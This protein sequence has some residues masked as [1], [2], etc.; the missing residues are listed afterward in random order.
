M[1]G[2]QLV[3]KVGRTTS[4]TT[5]RVIGKLQGPIIIPYASSIHNFSGPVYLDS[6]FTIAGQIGPFSDSGDSGSLVVTTPDANGVRSAVG[7]IFGK[8]QDGSAPGGIVSLAL[9]IS[10]ILQRLNVT[11]VHGHNV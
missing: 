1:V 4:H 11:L 5:G 7:I 9:P 10:P 3:E 6:V 2:N 8:M